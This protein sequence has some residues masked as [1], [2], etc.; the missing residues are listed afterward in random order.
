M[1]CYGFSL[2]LDVPA[3]TSKVCHR[4]A[5]NQL[6]LTLRDLTGAL[7]CLSRLNRPDGEPKYETLNALME[8]LLR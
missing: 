8:Q 2:N 3:L 5:S 4:I 6:T 1:M 7:T